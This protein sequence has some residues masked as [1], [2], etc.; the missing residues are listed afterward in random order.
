MHHLPRLALL[1]ITLAS[2]GVCSAQA[3]Y[4][5]GSTY[6]QQPCAPDARKVDIKV[7]DPCDSEANR[8]K[9]ECYN[10]PRRTDAA[11]EKHVSEL[12]AGIKAAE[13]ENEKTVDKMRF[14]IP[15]PQQV[16]SNKTKCL[17]KISSSLKDP[18]SAKF[19]SVIRIGPELDRIERVSVPRFWYSVMVN[20]KNSYG[21]YTGEKT[22]ICAFMP[23]EITLERTWQ[24][25]T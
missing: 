25:G 19:G 20:A 22:H 8:W 23:D 21:G 14:Q 17:E 11:S 6:S 2:T 4:R 15:A 18:D 3:V 12:A 24:V 13:D 5:C 10:R 9:S 7:A 16:A 1:S